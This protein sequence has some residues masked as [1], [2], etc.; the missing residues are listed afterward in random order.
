[1]SSRLENAASPNQD[2][3]IVENPYQAPPI[4]TDPASL[5][6]SSDP[7]RAPIP[8]EVRLALDI[9]IAIE[10]T[11]LL[12]A[13]GVL[14]FAFWERLPLFYTTGGQVLM[15]VIGIASLSKV[16]GLSI[17][18]RSP[19]PQRRVALVCAVVHPI[20]V[21]VMASVPARVLSD[22]DTG[23]LFILFA[24]S[25]YALL[26]TS[27][28]ML[29]VATRAIAKQFS[30]RSPQVLCDLAI[31]AYAISAALCSLNAL[32]TLPL[33]YEDAAV[34]GS[35]ATCLLGLVI[36]VTG[37]FGLRRGLNNGSHSNN[38]TPSSDRKPDNGFA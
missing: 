19:G 1:M 25:A 38:Q 29:A 12:A 24:A 3:K 2:A 17:W 10:T 14:G 6:A 30:L 20:A 4:T 31:V 32:N 23:G 9:L 21:V 7:A 27:Q 26:M 33:M 28:A 16:V 15:G 36:Q 8:R 35:I 13:L 22:G 37:L 18:G 5:W 11:V 34:L